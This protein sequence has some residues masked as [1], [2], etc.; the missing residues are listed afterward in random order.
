VGQNKIPGLGGG[1][2]QVNK[3]KAQKRS[4][5]EWYQCRQKKVAGATTTELVS[6]G[7]RREVVCHGVG[8]AAEN[9]QP[10]KRES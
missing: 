8:N 6:T 9:S 5:T 1:G 3:K 4:L 7:K 10:K 2:G